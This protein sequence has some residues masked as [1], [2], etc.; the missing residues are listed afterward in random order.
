VF[1]R[2]TPGGS[3]GALVNAGLDGFVQ[4]AVIE[5]PRGLRLNVVSPGWVAETLASMGLD[6]AE[7]TLAIDVARSYVETVEGTGQGL[8]I[9]PKKS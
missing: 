7:G 1:E 5:M 4:A 3:F 2:P 6:G 8:T 9:R